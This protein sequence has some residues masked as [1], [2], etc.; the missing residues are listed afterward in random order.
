M[1]VSRHIHGAMASYVKTKA[2]KTISL[3]KFTDGVLALGLQMLGHPVEVDSETHGVV[4][5]LQ[6]YIEAP[7]GSGRLS[8]DGPKGAA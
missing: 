4:I 8:G 2:D 6:K 1:K 5:E 7:R 3:R